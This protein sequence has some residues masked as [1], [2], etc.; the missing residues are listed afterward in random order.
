MVSPPNYNM[1]TP[2]RLRKIE[3]KLSI[4][5]RN[6]RVIWPILGGASG[7]EPYRDVTPKES[8]TL[9]NKGQPVPI[10][11]ALSREKEF[12]AYLESE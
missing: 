10:C 11:I 6:G 4:K 8:E 12:L 1:N 3:A 7:G 2:A 5:Q 9:S